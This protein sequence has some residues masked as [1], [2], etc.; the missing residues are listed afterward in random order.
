MN[1]AG[2]AALRELIGW[3]RE[4]DRL[5]TLVQ[6]DRYCWNT[7]RAPWR[8]LPSRVTRSD[9]CSGNAH[10][11]WRRQAVS[12]AWNN[13]LLFC[14]SKSYLTFKSQLMS[15]ILGSISLLPWLGYGP[16]GSHS[17]LCSTCVPWHLVH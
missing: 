16:V 4:R 5:S 9:L 17:P 1:W 8:S 3:I 10:L 11:N 15:L 2:P 12:S 7:G 13:S 14:L 6:D